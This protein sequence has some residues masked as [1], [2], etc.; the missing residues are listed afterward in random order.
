VNK[1]CILILLLTSLCA[2]L[3]PPGKVSAQTA[4]QEVFLQFRHEGV[5]NTFI[6]SIYYQDRFYLSVSDLFSALSIDLNVDTGRMQLSGNF[7]GRGEYLLQLDSRNRTAQFDGR[8]LQ[9]TADDYILSDLGYYLSPEIFYELFGMEFLIDFNNLVLTLESEDTMPVVAQRERERQR[10]RMLRTQRELRRDFFPL[11][12]DR[13]KQNFYGGYF[14]YN[15]TGS[16]NDLGSSFL[17]NTSLGTELLGGD[18]QGTVFGNV[19]ENTTAIRSSGLRWRYG[20]LDN[21]WISSV[22]TGQ[23]TSL[24]LLPVAYTG[25]KLTNEPLEPRFLYGETAFNGIVEPGSEVELY[26]NNSLV[27]YVQADETGQYRFMVPITYG[28]SNYSIRVYDPTGQVSTR[29]VRL[30]VPF[31]FLPPGEINYT[32]DAGRLDNPIAGSPD[33]GFMSRA[34]V[35]AGLTNRFSALAGMEY[36]E[37]FHENLP[38]VKAGLSSRLFENYLLSVEAA[39]QAFYRATGSVIYPSNASISLDYTRYNRDGGIYNPARNISSWRTNLFVPFEIRN[40]PL[41]VRFNLSNENRE[42]S[43]VS[44][45]RVDLNTRLGRANIRLGYRDTQVGRFSLE[46]SPVARITASATYNVSRSRTVPAVLRGVFLRAQTN[47]LPAFSQIEDA[48][49]Q[50]SRNIRQT[51]RLQISMGRNFTGG[52]NLFRFGFTVD[53]S[54]IRSVTTV[55]STRTASAFTQSLR[56]SVG[57]DPSN[58]NTLFTNRQQVGRSGT[59]VRLFVDHN[60]SGAF[61]PDEDE[62]I[63]ENA[64]RIDRAGGI[65]VSKDS[66]HYLSQLQP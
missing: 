48:E 54:S 29:D 27:D 13:N 25:V 44:R 52:F 23:T 49:I 18:L 21:D 8:T 28:A 26:R 11:R 41:F 43:S 39:S 45:Y 16:Y 17:Y 2:L 5:V 36:F 24:G 33:R 1:K 50:F 9:L 10:E 30:Q 46:S 6:S 47:Y 3:P 60:N 53:F 51:G 14:D 15:L 19:S 65:P 38:T 4:D 42:L 58:K 20:I 22:T 12:F 57:Y 63:P 55:R 66:I 35:T 56:G 7:I 61:E 64:V 40:L 31:N 34:D 59:A 37:D 32:V 62:L